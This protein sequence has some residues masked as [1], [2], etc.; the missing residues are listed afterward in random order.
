MESVKARDSRMSKTEG[1][2]GKMA[3]I[4]AVE[5]GCKTVGVNGRHRNSDATR[6]RTAMVD[7]SL[8]RYGRDLSDEPN[9]ARIY[10]EMGEIWGDEATLHGEGM[11]H[12]RMEAPES[13]LALSGQAG[14]VITKGVVLLD[15]PRLEKPW[16]IEWGDRMRAGEEDMG[17]QGMDGKDGLIDKY[18]LNGWGRV[19]ARSKRL[20]KGFQAQK[21]S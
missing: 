15:G 9:L 11:C 3:E 2:D 5:V 12:R 6:T 18:P 20:M 19:R 7:P 17:R 8:E 16:S 14:S 13:I 1:S 10:A 4:L 21:R